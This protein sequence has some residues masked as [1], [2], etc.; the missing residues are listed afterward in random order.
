[1]HEL[2]SEIMSEANVGLDE[3]Q[4]AEKRIEVVQSGEDIIYDIPDE[5]GRVKLFVNAA[6]LKL[7]RKVDSTK[8]IPELTALQISITLCSIID[9]LF[10]IVLRMSTPDLVIDKVGVR[11]QEG[12][13]KLVRLSAS[14]DTWESIKKQL[15]L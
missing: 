3:L 13:Y 10:W 14:N 7:L 9:N 1:M 11:I 2:T 8:A 6:G 12:A 15:E 5:L 4:E